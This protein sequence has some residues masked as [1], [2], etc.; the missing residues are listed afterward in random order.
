MPL[1]VTSPASHHENMNSTCPR[2]LPQHFNGCTCTKVEPTTHG[3]ELDTSSLIG[4]DDVPMI[5]ED[6]SLLVDYADTPGTEPV[7][8]PVRSDD[9]FLAD[10]AEASVTAKDMKKGEVMIDDAVTEHL[11]SDERDGYTLSRTMV[12]TLGRPEIRNRNR[13]VADI[14]RRLHGSENEDVIRM[15][16]DNRQN[17]TLLTISRAG[18]VSVKQGKLFTTG[19]G[20][21]A[22]LPKGSRAN[23][24]LLNTDSVVA[25]Q[26]GYVPPEAVASQ[27]E[28]AK[29]RY[30]PETSAIADFYDVP[31]YDPDSADFTDEAKHNIQA[32]YLVDQPNFDGGTSAGCM[33]LVTDKETGEN[34]DDTILYGQFY[35]PEGSGLHSEHSSYR[36][37]DLK[38]RG[39]KIDAYK[40]GS[41]SYEDA[42]RD[43]PSNSD[44]AF[45]KVLGRTYTSDGRGS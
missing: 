36:A 32:A 43:M 17:V 25:V 15:A 38:R 4:P 30:V 41:M 20:E 1:K 7:D 31:E 14:Y 21:V 29:A 19:D 40:K 13:A 33:F 26:K 45:R 8:A 23:G 22:I 9:P 39:A 16:A 18:S 2:N 24:F 34:D 37:S 35:A 42:W 28:E 12:H 27:W 5:G 3:T 11:A 44:Q 10:V 6:G